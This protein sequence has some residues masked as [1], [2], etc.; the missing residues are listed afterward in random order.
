MP[1]R[2]S[3]CKTDE[4]IKRYWKDGSIP[5]AKSRIKEV[6]H[7]GGKEKANPTPFGCDVKKVL[8]VSNKKLRACEGAGRRNGFWK[9]SNLKSVLF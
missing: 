7:K 5:K 3:I 1:F 6:R 8:E 4:N 9:K 2:I